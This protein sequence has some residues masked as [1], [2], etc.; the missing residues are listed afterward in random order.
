M[1]D[2]LQII[3][4]VIIYIRVSTKLQESKYSLAGQLEELIRYAQE[5]GWTIVATYK[6]TDSGGKLEKEGM[7]KLLNDVEEG[8]TDIVLV[9]DQDRLSRLNVTEWEYLK[10]IL[11]ENKVKIAEPGNMVDLTD[12]YDEFFSDIK[13]LIARREKRNIV[14]RMMRGKRQKMREGKGWGKPPI[15]YTFNKDTKKYGI[16]EEW[17]WVIPAID[18]MYLEENLGMK[19]IADKLNGISKTPTNTYWNETLV[20][21]RLISKAFHGVMEKKFSNDETIV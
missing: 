10:S 9:V 2:S 20:Y 15:G 1:S 11:R 19:A 21:R 13:N 7:D 5:Q 17:A 18:K 6:D 3:I 12:E 4:R 8:K 14:R 16:N